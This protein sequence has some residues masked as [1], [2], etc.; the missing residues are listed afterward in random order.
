M[1]FADK[2]QT[3]ASL[4]RFITSAKVLEQNVFTVGDWYRRPDDIIASIRAEA[5][6][7]EA[8]VVRSSVSV[9]DSETHSL[10]GKF[11]SVLNV[12]TD[13]QLR[14]A[15]ETV[16]D[17]YGDFAGEN[18][19]VLVQPMLRNVTMSGVAVSCELGSGRPYFVINYSNGSNTTAVTS[20][21]TN[22]LEV[23][24]HFRAARRS[25]S[26]RL[27]A[28]IRLLQEI[29]ELTKCDAV[30]IEFAFCADS[31]QPILLQA[32]R[33]ANLRPAASQIET[34]SHGLQTAHQKAEELLDQHALCPGGG[35][36]LGIMPDWNPAE[37]IGVRPKPLAL[38]LYRTL[39]TDSVWAEQRR[40][41]GYRDLRGFPL[42]IDLLGLPFIDVR[43]SFGSFV[44]SA[45][46]E[47]LAEK[48]VDYYLGR[49]RKEPSLHDK[50][51]FEI[52]FSCYSFDLEDRL[53][54]LLDHGFQR[55]DCDQIKAALR[56]LTL[57]VMSPDEGPWA[58]DRHQIDL[59]A[60]RHPRIKQSNLTPVSHIYWLL[61]D[62]RR[63][64]TRPFAGLA[65]AGFIAMQLLDSLVEAEVF[66]TSD[67]RKLLMGLNSVSARMQS[68]MS[69]LARPQFLERYG[70]LRPGTYDILS[71][72]YDE[73]PDFYLHAEQPLGM[74]S[75]VDDQKTE[76]S[77]T[78]EQRRALTALL[79]S[80]EFSVAPDN[81]L[82]FLSTAI[83]EREQAKF[84]FS[85][86]LSDALSLF[87]EWGS[88][89]GFSA[90][91]LSYADIEIVR[92]CHLSTEDPRRLLNSS[93][94]RGKKSFD[95]TTQTV[96]PPLIRSAEEVWGFH[97]PVATPTFVTRRLAQ[98]PVLADFNDNAMEGCIVLLP[99]A[100]PG[101]DWIFA[102][103][104]AGFVTAYGGAN[105]HMAVRASELDLPAVVGAGERL[106]AKWRQAPALKIDCANRLV[107]VLPL[108]QRHET[109]RRYAAG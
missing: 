94:E 72:R 4:S 78:S 27:G 51:E 54:A 30:D 43:A 48:L 39:V 60:R 24:Y 6:A 71:S 87:T 66:A 76:F 12:E 65:R 36:I 2:S 85:R 16:V 102:R 97:L 32:R 49:L 68:D 14:H 99:N 53:E 63:H 104:I 69:R 77:I 59:L 31:E 46:D 45:L 25:P 52:V 103:G 19:H 8:V 108:A 26:G 40:D 33:L 95:V 58:Y 100:D 20:G 18:E 50:V 88:Q 44:P 10:A 92:L 106:F 1:V 38:S 89:L 17:S 41:Y 74:V 3:L 23:Y 96:F 22:D 101:F 67:R 86:N 11:C 82:W 5:W 13:K 56:D 15:I 107:E 91:D 73:E 21:H 105:S 42:M 62:C 93:I 81:F 79:T 98:A 57:M 109:H 37:I 9:E 55:S 90:D 29:E 47:E 35:S 7:S 28:V 80:H 70:H 64:G 34:Q 84:E 75:D 61:E 83:R